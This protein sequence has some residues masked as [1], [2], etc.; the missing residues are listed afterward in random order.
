MSLSHDDVLSLLTGLAKSD[1]Q[2]LHL[3]VP[4]RPLLRQRET[5]SLLPTDH[6]AMTPAAT[7]RIATLLLQIA[8]VEVPLAHT[9]HHEFGFGVPNVGRFHAVIYRQR[10]S[11]A[12][13]VRRLSF[14]PPSLLE[15]GLDSTVEDIF[16][17]RGLVLIA[18]NRRRASALNALVDRYNSNHRGLVVII[19]DPLTHLHR[20]GTA[21]IAQRG[22]GTDVP[23]VATGVATAKRQGADLIAVGDVPDRDTAEKVLRAAEHGSLVLACVTAPDANLAASWILRHYDSDRDADCKARLKRLLRTVI[24]VPDEGPSRVVHRRT[25]LRAAS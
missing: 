8:R 2:E 10:G 1:A 11:V 5:G 13:V 16:E 3:K 18:G 24:N 15:L 19:E 22:V 20:D 17:E 4:A 21:T 12:L 14:A 23:D 6:P 9:T 25:S 7:H